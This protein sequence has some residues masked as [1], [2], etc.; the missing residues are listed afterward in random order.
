MSDTRTWLTRSLF[1][2]GT[3]PDPR[4][5]LANERT[6]LAWVRT[7]LAFLAGGIA[8]QA[9]DIPSLSTPVQHFGALVVVA[10]A[11]IIAVASAV[12]WVRVERAMRLRRPLPAPA[13]IPLLV[14][15]LL[16]GCGVVLGG[17]LS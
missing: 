17:L 3:E 8:L 11:L 15:A 5:T 4:F 16:V 13:L 9:F 10:V 14:V 7:S 12:R 6:F 2:D 1:P